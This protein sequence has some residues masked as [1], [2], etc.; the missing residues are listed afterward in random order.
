MIGEHKALVVQDNLRISG[1]AGNRSLCDPIGQIGQIVDHGRDQD[2]AQNTVQAVLEEY[3]N[4]YSSPE[5][6]HPVRQPQDKEARPRIEAD[7]LCRS[8]ESKRCAAEEEIQP[9]SVL[10]PSQHEIIHQQDKKDGIAV[11]GSNP[12]LRIVHEPCRQQD[13]AQE[14]NPFPAEQPSEKQIHQREHQHAGQRTGKAPAK[15]RHTEEQDPESQEFFPQRRMGDL[16]RPHAV[17]ILPGCPGMVYFVKIAGVSEVGAFRNGILFIRE[18]R[19][20]TVPR[21]SFVIDVEEADFPQPRGPRGAVDPEIPS[22]VC[23]AQCNILPFQHRDVILGEGLHREPALHVIRDLYAVFPLSN[24][25]KQHQHGGLRRC[26]EVHHGTAPGHRDK[27]L[28]G[29]EIPKIPESGDGI[30]Y[31]HRQDTPFRSSVSRSLRTAAGNLRA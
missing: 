6:T 8:A 25:G 5:L 12:R 10:Q 16:I 1:A 11:D 7:P 19:E 3:R 15:G 23:K 31:R 9:L 18:L 24:A 14:R 28:G 29:A 22:G 27:G 21:Q 2:K 30:Q 13:R 20:S 4:G 26:L 17:Q